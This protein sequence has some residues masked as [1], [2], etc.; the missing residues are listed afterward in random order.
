M[1]LL[2]GFFLIY[3][4]FIITDTFWFHIYDLLNKRTLEN[5]QNVI[6]L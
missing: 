4:L 6:L 2:S 1:Q 5:L 3:F